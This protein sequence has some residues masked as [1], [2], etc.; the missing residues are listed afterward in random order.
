MKSFTSQVEQGGEKSVCVGV[1]V[2]RGWGGGRAA[3]HAQKINESEPVLSPSPTPPPSP[4]N[5]DIHRGETN[6]LRRY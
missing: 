1:C 6:H 4:P 3:F 2:G 5:R